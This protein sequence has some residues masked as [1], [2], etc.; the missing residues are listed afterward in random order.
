MEI[1]WGT[2][3]VQQYKILCKSFKMCI[4]VKQNQERLPALQ[5]FI[6]IPIYKKAFIFVKPTCGE[7]DIVVTI[8]VRCIC[9][10]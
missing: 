10:H 2:E 1:L 5:T 4:F 9:V 8:F 7:R 3:F 6:I